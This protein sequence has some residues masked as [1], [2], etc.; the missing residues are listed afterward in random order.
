MMDSY[1]FFR[2]PRGLTVCCAEKGR[3]V[4]TEL[5]KALAERSRV[6]SHHSADL[7]VQSMRLLLRSQELKEIFK[8]IL[9]KRVCRT[10]PAAA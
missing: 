4:A 9:Q 1:A 3:R 10:V 8:K 2:Y 6:L 5:S 7:S